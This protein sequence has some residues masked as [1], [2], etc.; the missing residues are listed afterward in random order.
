MNLSTDQQEAADIFRKFLKNKS[1]H[2]MAISGKGGTG[3]SFLTKHLIEIARKE[4]EMEA[5]LLDEEDKL[6]LY[7]TATTNQAAKV[8]S[9]NTQEYAGTIHSLLGL[10]VQND[11]KTGKQ[12]LAKTSDSR[13]IDG[14]LIFIDEASM[15]DQ[16]LLDTIRE[17]TL[18]C[19]VV[20]IG[21]SHQLAPVFEQ[22][23]PVFEQVK[24]QY[25]LTTFQRQIAG[26]P[27][28]QLAEGFREAIHSGTFPEIVPQGDTIQ[29]VD[30]PRFKELIDETYHPG[31][32][33]NE[34]RVLAWTNARVHQY[35]EYIRSILTPHKDYQV[36]EY[37]RTNNPIFS[38][39]QKHKSVAT[40]SILKIVDIE[41]TTQY[42][43]EGWFV[44]L[45]YLQPVFLPK[46][47][48]KATQYIKKLAKEKK[49]SEYFE[50]KEYFADL[51][52]IYANTVNK[53]QG[54]TY[55]TTFIDLEDIAKNRKFYEVARLLYV[56]I[57]RSSHKVIMQK[58]LPSKYS[59]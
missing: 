6:S 33:I 12:F 22:S 39:T 1:I 8:L 55:H 46:N 45:D 27:I 30:G 14:S 34:A 59:S 32:E 16:K 2:E 50:V 24:L 20:Y 43:L 9:I 37:L 44:S 58:G 21:D 7:C 48:V 49:W 17:S 19:K 13:V 4:S 29:L 5:F 47:Q 31:I 38:K 42:G 3:K 11:F 25:E 23:C 57:T 35:N 41:E 28:I 18:N 54:S 26:S 51:R 10:K 15:I 56:A 36:G 53:A 40:D 52:P